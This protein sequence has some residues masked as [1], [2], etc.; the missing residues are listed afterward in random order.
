MDGDYQL[1]LNTFGQ[2]VFTNADGAE[3]VNIEAVRAFPITAATESIALLAQDGHEL[4]WIPNLDSLAEPL[5]A[6]VMNKLA[7]SGFMPEILR[8]K[9]VS[10]FST[11][12]TWQVETDH[13]DT[14]LILKTEED[15]RLLAAPTLLIVDSRGIQ[16]LIRDPQALDANSRKILDRFL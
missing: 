11:P 1:H 12:S 5:R 3:H 13:G 9:S 2:L 10:S 16:F 7:I 8:V 15:I 4:A 14:H 6:I